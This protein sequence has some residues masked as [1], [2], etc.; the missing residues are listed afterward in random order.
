MANSYKIETKKEGVHG[1]KAV[2][3]FGIDFSVSN[4]YDCWMLPASGKT[5]KKTRPAKNTR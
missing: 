1:E 5:S 4:V 2:D 3:C